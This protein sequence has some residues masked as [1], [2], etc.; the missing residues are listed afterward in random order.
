MLEH[1]DEPVPLLK[2]IY[3]ILA[4][5]AYLYVEVPSSERDVSDYGID[6]H[7]WFY[8]PDSLRY[9]LLCIGFRD[10]NVSEGTFNPRLHNVPFIFAA[11]R[12]P[13]NLP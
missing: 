11:A 1:L 9:L 7:F 12:K 5:G 4:D 13:G 2:E 10:V 8:S 6:D 3:R